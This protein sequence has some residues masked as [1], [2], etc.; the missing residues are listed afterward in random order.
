MAPEIE[1][2]QEPAA[3]PAISGEEEKRI[4]QDQRLQFIMTYDLPHNDQPGGSAT[5]NMTAPQASLDKE[6]EAQ[7]GQAATFILEDPVSLIFL[8]S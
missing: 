5:G 3:T 4:R 2:P 7:G 6:N 8:P 1:R